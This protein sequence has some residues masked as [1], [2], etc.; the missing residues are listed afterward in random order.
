MSALPAQQFLFQHIREML[1]EHAS[2]A[3]VIGTV[4]F[5]ST[6]SAYRRIRCETPLTLDETRM[7]CEHFNLSLDQLFHLG[8]NKVVF[9]N[10]R[11]DPSNYTFGMFLNGLQQQM[12]VIGRF[13]HKEIIYLTKDIPLFHSFY[14][15]PLFAFRYFFWMKSVIC[16][17]SFARA[18]FTIDCLP[19][20]IETAGLQLC[21]TYNQLTSIEIWNT[22]CVNSIIAQVEFYYEA[23]YIRNASEVNNI[24][25][26][27]IDSMLHLQK[28]AEYGAKFMIN[29]NPENK[30]VN[31]KL[32]HNTTV[33]GDNT[34]L[35]NVDIGSTVFLNYDVLN[36]MHTSDKKFCTEMNEMLSSLMRRSTLIST[37]NEKQRFRFFNILIDKIRSRKK[38]V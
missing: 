21:K 38:N 7:L 35:V 36:Y 12:D 29:E 33:L 22:E 18:V 5:L 3:D 4:L 32:F 30:Q 34:I 13:N 14:F 26:S 27:V 24:Y 25:K 8:S 19:P 10:N 23:G 31:F 6:D 15:R 2:L 20:A 17:P 16:D 11:I 1:P 28:Q 37:E 9:Q